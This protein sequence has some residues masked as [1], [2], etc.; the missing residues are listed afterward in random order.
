[1]YNAMLRIR[2]ELFG[3]GEHVECRKRQT[4][5][6]FKAKVP[7]EEAIRVRQTRRINILT[8]TAK[9]DLDMMLKT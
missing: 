4:N 2:Y 8:C 3:N 6:L 5:V 7:E 9:T 1:M